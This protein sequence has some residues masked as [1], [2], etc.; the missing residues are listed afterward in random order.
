MRRRL[1]LLMGVTIVSGLAIWAVP[2]ERLGVA[3]A[4]VP[5]AS[6]RIAYVTDSRGC[7]DC[8]VFTVAPDGSDPVKLTDL[9]VGGPR[10]SPDGTRLSFPAIAPDGRIT[11]ATIDA[12]GTDFRMFDLDHPTRNRPYGRLFLVHPD[13]TGLHEVP[14]R[15]PRGAGA[16]E[17]SWTPDGGWIV[18][19]VGRDQASDL[20]AVR[21][22]GTDLTRITGSDGIV[23]S[24]PDWRPPAPP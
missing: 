6:G 17:P 12:D 1:S 20:Y 16:S 13:G 10:W 14:R 21:P 11:T 24:G 4:E 9:A 19:V 8:H 23:V 2:G 18:F 3:T 15:L 22:D 7:D 5:G